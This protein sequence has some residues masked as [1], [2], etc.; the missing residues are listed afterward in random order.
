[1]RDQLPCDPLTWDLPVVPD[2]PEW[3]TEIHEVLG[4]AACDADESTP[5]ESVREKFCHRAHL[6]AASW[7]RSLPGLRI[8]VRENRRASAGSGDLRNGSGRENNVDLPTFNPRLRFSSGEL[9]KAPVFP[10]ER[11]GA[12][13]VRAAERW[14]PSHRLLSRGCFCAPS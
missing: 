3:Q 5:R 14:P 9:G 4:R 10:G 13:R 6:P 7:L 8:R 2:L 12:I 1:M 11:G